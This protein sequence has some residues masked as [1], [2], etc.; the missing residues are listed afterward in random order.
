MSY[1]NYHATA[2]SLI[3]KGKLKGY[4]FEE[5]YNGISPVLLLHFD[6]IKHP[7]MPIR[8]SRWEEYFPLLTESNE[9]FKND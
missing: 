2:K 9:I 8:K 7:I 4:S 5:K 3:K 1:F 6:D